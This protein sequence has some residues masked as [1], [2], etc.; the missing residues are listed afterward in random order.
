VVSLMQTLVIALIPVLPRLLNT[1]AADT[2]WVITATLLAGA[3]A[4]P[5]VGRLGDMYGKRRMLL[6]SLGILVA[7]STVAA[8]SDT[9]V[10]MVVGR[11][12]QGLA[13]GVIP[14]GISIMRD[15]LP[16]ERLGSAT[17]PV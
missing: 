17:A 7:G 15:E 6:I 13:A 5:V 14:L 2:P 16:S 4:T 9:L 1:S 3:V 8:L 11:A 12:L 10:P